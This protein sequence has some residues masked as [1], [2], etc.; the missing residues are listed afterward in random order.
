MSFALFKKSSSTK[1]GEYEPWFE[2][3]GRAARIE[4]SAYVAG[5]SYFAGLMLVGEKTIIAAIDHAPWVFLVIAS[6]FAA[7]LGSVVIIQGRMGFAASANTF[8][9][10]N[11]LVT[12]GIFQYSRNP[13]FLAFWL[14]LLSL[15]V[16]SIPA[17][18]FA[19]ALYIVVMN[20]TVLRTEE[21]DLSTLFGHVYT[22]YAAR[23]PRW[24]LV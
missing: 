18:L 8:G 19:L 3:K 20:L 13:I 12:G 14:P 17:S 21:R 16:L 7:F 5:I 6:C 24:I 4:L 11:H 9:K 22:D 2:L 10:P 23:V 1:I 15:T